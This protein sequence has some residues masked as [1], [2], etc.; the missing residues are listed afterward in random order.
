MRLTAR[1]AAA[2]ALAL[3]AA[4]TSTGLPAGEPS[5]AAEIQKWRAE[6]E[7]HLKADGGWLSVAGLFWLKPGPNAFGSDPTNAIVLPADSA[8]AH[9]GIFEFADGKTTLRVEPGVMITS[10]GKPVTMLDLKPDTSGA[11]DELTLGA[12]SMYV[13]QRGDRYG[14]RLKD[15]HSARRRE[16]KGLRWFPIRESYRVTARFVAYDTPQPIPIPN[17]LCQVNELPSPGYVVF[18]LGGQQLRLDPVLEAPDDSELFFIFR[19]ETSAKETYGGGRFLYSEMP[20]DGSV[21]LD[22]NKAYSPPCAFT[23][24]ATCPLPPP[25]NWLPLRVEAGEL[26]YGKPSH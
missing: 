18:K 26:A 4:S 19:D 15:V 11:G 7:A 12:L 16:F 1:L 13:I 14:I 25:Q 21:V 8:P 10:A 2:L 17:V 23:P 22:F 3:A 9:A 20:K 6:R 5:Y 24:F